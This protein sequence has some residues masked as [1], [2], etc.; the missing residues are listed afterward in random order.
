MPIRGVFGNV[1]DLFIVA[2]NGCIAQWPE[3]LTADQQ[4]SSSNLDAL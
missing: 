4:V 3:Q 2:P 1:C